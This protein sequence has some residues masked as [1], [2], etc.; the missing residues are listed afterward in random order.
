MALA[1]ALGAQELRVDHVTVAGRDLRAMQKALQNIGIRSEYG[2]PHSNHATEMALVSFPDGSYLELIAIQP[3][4]D[5][6]AVAAH[7]WRK[8]LE[9]DG[10]PT[11]WAVRP[12]DFSAEVERLRKTGVAVSEPRPNGRK[13]PDGVELKWETAQ[14]GPGNGTFFPF[15]IHDF[16]PR[17]RRAYP[18][19]KFTTGEWTGI[20]K[21][22]LAVSDLD[23]AVKQFQFAY[24]LPAPQRQDDPAFGAKLAW[25]RGTPVVLATPLTPQSWLRVRLDRFGE[26]PCAYLLGL[27]HTVDAHPSQWF[28]HKV[29]W[30]DSAKLGWHLGFEAK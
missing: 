28:G 14:I 19:G 2:G 8:F 15:L 30:V 29:V 18:S 13:R 26:S 22:V 5:P 6:K 4:A 23:A 25:F 12:T 21:V 10:G 3:N 20:T 9:G 17:E 7:E 11:S 16:T 24:K 27:N 1:G